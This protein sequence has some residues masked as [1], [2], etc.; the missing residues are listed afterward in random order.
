MRRERR[1]SDSADM[2][3]FLPIFL[4]TYLL[5][6]ALQP[7][8]WQNT[9]PLTLAGVRKSQYNKEREYAGIYMD[10]A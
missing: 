2:S 10:Y 1:K 3:L 5:I 6:R 9:L 8:D 4:L 7:D